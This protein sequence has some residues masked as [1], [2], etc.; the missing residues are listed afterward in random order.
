MTKE[1]SV[2]ID[3]DFPGRKITATTRFSSPLK[4]VWTAFTDSTVLEKWFAPKPYKA[5]TKSMEF[6]NGG[7]W[8]YYML[9]P[10]GEKI[11]SMED[12]D[13]IHPME[14]FE[15]LDRFVD[16][17]G[18]IDD[19]LPQPHWRYTFSQEHGQVT[20]TAILSFKSEEEMRKILEMGFEQ[21]FRMGLDQ[22]HE[23][24]D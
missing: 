18:K 21:G 16:K 24:M 22:L 14:S 3:K 19:N 1:K 4:T 8:L 12:F 11:W 23:I 10:K 9:S 20:V 5:V 15:A 2:K 17:D 7:R 6:R 13:N